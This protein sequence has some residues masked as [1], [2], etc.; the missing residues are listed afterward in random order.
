MTSEVKMTLATC[1]LPVPTSEHLGLNSQTWGPLQTQNLL[2]IATGPNL[3]SFK[4]AL[5]MWLQSDS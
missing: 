3:E 2:V 5:Q 4:S 1:R